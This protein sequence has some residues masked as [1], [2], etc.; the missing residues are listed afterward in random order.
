M[1]LPQNS[2]SMEMSDQISPSNYQM[3]S[4]NSAGNTPPAVYHGNHPLSNHANP[5]YNQQSSPENS[6]AA[7]CQPTYGKIVGPVQPTFGPQTTNGAYLTSSCQLTESYQSPPQ[8]YFDQNVTGGGPPNFPAH[9]H[10]MVSF[11]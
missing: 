3:S 9:P 7:P 6:S 11:F 5:Y 8:S 10:S 4:A 1:V 2:N